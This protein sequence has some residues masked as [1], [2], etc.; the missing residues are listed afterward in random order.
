MTTPVFT[1]AEGVV[2]AWV[3]SR[4]TLVGVG[5]PLQKGAM[6]NRQPGAASVAYALLSLV[7][8]GEAPF[9]VES[10]TQVARISA[11]IYGRTKEQASK[12]A[13][14]YANELVAL[15]LRGPVLVT[16]ISDGAWTSATILT[17]DGMS[18]PL[19]MPDVGEPR[20]VVD[21]DFYLA[22]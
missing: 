3:N 19:W 13:T 2:R 4:P 5:R 7:G 20:Y 15:P 6:L 21:A 9:G 14:A 12:A 1:D 11:A 16:W 8:G 17:V 18:G 10:P 22:T